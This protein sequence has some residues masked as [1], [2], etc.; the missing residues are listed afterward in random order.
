MHEPK[1]ESVDQGKEIQP[2]D[3]QPRLHADIVPGSLMPGFPNLEEEL[4]IIGDNT[5]KA[6][7]NVPSHSRLFIDSP[8]E[9]GSPVALSFSNEEP[10]PWCH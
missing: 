3:V 2:R 6:L 9:H 8:C 7:P 10:P 4:R 1:Q 5:I